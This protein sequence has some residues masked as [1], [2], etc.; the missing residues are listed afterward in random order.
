MQQHD[1]Q[2]LLET[3][4]AL[5]S[6]EEV[7][8]AVRMMAADISAAMSGSRPLAL[9]VMTGATVF[10]GKLLPLLEFPLEFDYLQASRYHNRTSGAPET[11]G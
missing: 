1:P 8:A 10:A 11:D 6:E 2:Q 5:F 4:D 7:N 3:S 9:C